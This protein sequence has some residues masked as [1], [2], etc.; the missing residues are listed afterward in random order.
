MN[1][2]TQST[3]LNDKTQIVLIKYKQTDD[4][5]NSIGAYKNN[6]KK[7]RREIHSLLLFIFFLF[8]TVITLSQILVMHSG[9]NNSNFYQI[10]LMQEELKLMDQSIDKMLKE[11][12]VIPMQVWYA[13][14]QYT[15]N[16]D[17]FSSMI[18]NNNNNNN[19]TKSNNLNKNKLCDV[20]PPVLCKTH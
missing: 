6:Q 20:Q 17:T 2:P 12:H 5:D 11:R 19:I 18:N 14:K 4:D 15:N 13:L 8:V 1:P 9:T 3:I 7:K 16:F 10:K